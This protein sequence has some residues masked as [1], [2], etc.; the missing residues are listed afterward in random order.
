MNISDENTRIAKYLAMD[1]DD[2]KKIIAMGIENPQLYSQFL[3]QDELNWDYAVAAGIL[4]EDDVKWIK[5]NA[6]E[7]P[8]EEEQES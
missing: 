4:T 3:E 1:E 8:S 6:D 2:V 5:E 7:E